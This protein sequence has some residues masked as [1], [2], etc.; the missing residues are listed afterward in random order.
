ML[1]Y[2]V[3]V[4]V[5]I[6]V[7]LIF[8][9]LNPPISKADLVPDMTPLSAKKDVGMTDEVQKTL[10]G[11][12]GSTVTAFIKLLDGDRTAR[13][14][15]SAAY[16]PLLFVANNW[17]LE[18]APSPVTETGKEAVSARLRVSSTA[19]SI[20]DEIIDLPPIPKQKWVFLAIL[21]EGRRFDVIYQNRIVASHRLQHYPVVVASPLSVGNS[22]LEGSVIHVK[23]VG[24]RVA[25]KDVER[26]RLAHTDTNGAV[27]EEMRISMPGFPSLSSVLPTCLP[28]LPCDPVVAPPSNNLMEWGSPYA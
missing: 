19:G 27:V 7:F 14:K 26:E 6:T 20:Q 15:P 24:S 25:P 3:L 4:A 18:V 21:R 8:Y 23:M 9:V 11:S 12:G 16:T 10:L 28:G 22:G 2:I 5:A 13:A 17:Y 1:V